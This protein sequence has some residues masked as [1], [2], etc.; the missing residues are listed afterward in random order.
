MKS[1][2]LVTSLA[3][4]LDRVIDSAVGKPDP[5]YAPFISAGCVSLTGEQADQKLIQIFR[6]TRK[7]QSVIVT[8]ALPWSPETYCGSHV[9]LQGIE[10]RNV[11]VPLHWDH[12]VSDLGA[13]RFR[14]GVVSTLPVSGVPLLLGND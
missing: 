6:D 12:L 1:V 7:A 5:I 8:D 14:V 11:P 2:G 10:T 13:G 9:M 4:P 3:H